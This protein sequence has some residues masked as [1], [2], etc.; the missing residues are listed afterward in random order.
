MDDPILWEPVFSR[1]EV[2]KCLNRIQHI[3]MG[4]TKVPTLLQRID[5]WFRLSTM[6]S[7]AQRIAAAIQWDLAIG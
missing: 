2:D 7:N 3:S 6:S 5:S 1:E 4:E